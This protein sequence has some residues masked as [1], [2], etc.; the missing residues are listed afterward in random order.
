MSVS[1]CDHLNYRRQVP[2]NDSEWEML[3][4]EP[5]GALRADRPT[6]RRFDNRADG[7][8]KFGGKSRC[9]GRAAFKVPL[10]CGLIFE[11]RFFVKLNF[12]A[13]DARVWRKSVLE[14]PPREQSSLCR[15]LDPRC[16]E[17]FPG[18]KLPPLRPQLRCPSCPGEIPPKRPAP[19][20]REQAP[21][22]TARE[23]AES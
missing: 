6:V 5:A 3:E 7:P 21:F 18:S 15:N 2:I 17:Q 12:L 4:H 1:N 20:R 13:G 22:A 16:G 11:Y 8:I 9:Y 23:P 10:K 14:F 19:R